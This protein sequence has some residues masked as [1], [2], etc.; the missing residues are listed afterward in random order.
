MGLWDWVWDLG[1]G[2]RGGDTDADREVKKFGAFL[3]HI[4]MLCVGGR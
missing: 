4:C 3:G 1:V 2:E